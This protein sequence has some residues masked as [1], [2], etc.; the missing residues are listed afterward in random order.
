LNIYLFAYIF[1]GLFLLQL[2]FDKLSVQKI[3]TQMNKQ[4][5]RQE[6]KDAFLLGALLSMGYCDPI[7]GGIARPF[8]TCGGN[9]I[10]YGMNKFSN[11]NYRCGRP[12]RRMREERRERF[13]RYDAEK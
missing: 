5:Y 10:P 13:W 9:F 3:D 1:F 4:C 6:K 8:F 2:F 7:F 11:P 12:V